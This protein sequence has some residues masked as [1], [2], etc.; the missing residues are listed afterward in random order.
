MSP[1]SAYRHDIVDLIKDSTSTEEWYIDSIGKPLRY[2]KTT[3]TKLISHKIKKIIYR[4]TYSIILVNDINFP[5][6]LASPPKGTYAQM[7]YFAGHPWKLYSMSYENLPA[8]NKK[9]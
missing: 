8:T 2:R 7:L 1:L 6:L 3:V 9:V 4:D 5:I